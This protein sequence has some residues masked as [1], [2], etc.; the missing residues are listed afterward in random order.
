MNTQLIYALKRVLSNSK[1]E[2]YLTQ[3]ELNEFLAYLQRSPTFKQMKTSYEKIQDELVREF[4][5]TKDNSSS[6]IN[7]AIHANK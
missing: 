4:K 5:L 1:V 6:L 7:Y 2:A 3:E